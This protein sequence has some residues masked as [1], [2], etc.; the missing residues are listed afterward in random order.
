M[1]TRKTRPPATQRNLRNAEVAA[2]MGM[3]THLTSRWR[4]DQNDM[5][6][7]QSATSATASGY[8]AAIKTLG[9]FIQSAA[10]TTGAVLAIYQEIS[11]G[12]MIGA[13]LLLGKTI[14]P[15]Q[16][17]VSSW[18]SFVDA[19]EQYLRLN[20]LLDTFPPGGEKMSLP[21]IAGHITATQAFVTP[22]GGKMPILKEVSLDLPAGTTT[23]VLGASAAGKSTLVR[24][25]LGLWPTAQGSIRI[26]GAEAHQFDRTELGPQIGYLPQDIELF[27]GTVAEN[28]ARFGEVI[29]E[30]VVQAAQD[31]GIH[32]LI[33]GLPEGY[34]TL[35]SVSQG[36]LSPGQRQR[37]ALAR[38]LYGRPKLLVLDEP[39]SNLD[40][41]GEQALAS[42]IAKSKAGGSSIIMVS[43]RQ[44][45]LPLVDYLIIMGDGRVLQQG[46]RDAV[47][48]KIKAAQAEVQASQESAMV[49]SEE[50]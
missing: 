48:A 28:I 3:I 21:D 23:M 45:A 2:A 31:A 46:P 19:R 20:D 6:E 35:I 34:D 14:Q 44:G 50:H 33:L 39:N 24:S 15:I 17:A 42:A 18:R 29:S 9:Q 40:E 26:D 12:V 1:L 22:P 25:I 13:A 30:Q 43:H 8:A 47:I 27:D 5:L 49:K 16:Q 41:A 11:P 37:I 38:A 10:I 7:L 32:E 4:N 36:R